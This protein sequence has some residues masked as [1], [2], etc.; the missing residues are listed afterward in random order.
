M[1]VPIDKYNGVVAMLKRA[2]DKIDELKAML[3]QAE[4]M[5]FEVSRE[6]CLRAASEFRGS[7]GRDGR[8]EQSWCVVCRAKAVAK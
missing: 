7:C 5:L 2:D 4:A 8:P 3:K 6:T 1:T